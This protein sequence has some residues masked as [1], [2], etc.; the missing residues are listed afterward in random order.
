MPIEVEVESLEQVRTALGTDADSLLLD[1]FSLEEMRQA[2]ALRDAA[3]GKRKTLEASGGLDF[4]TLRAV[5]ETGV[6]HISVGAMTK[7]LRAV[8]FSMRFV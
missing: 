6:Y 1:N 7:H 2:V 3:G 8:D 5:A 4:E